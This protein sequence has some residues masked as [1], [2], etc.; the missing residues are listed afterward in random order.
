M[1]QYFRCQIKKPNNESRKE[2]KR[3]SILKDMVEQENNKNKIAG[4][5][6][7]GRW[8]DKSNNFYDYR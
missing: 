2:E 3:M 5:D 7:R 8:T 4:G 1:L 6:G